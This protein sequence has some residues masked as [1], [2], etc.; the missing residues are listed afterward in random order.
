MKCLFVVVL[1]IAALFP[2]ASAQS[3]TVVVE[4][5]VGGGLSV[6]LP[7]SAFGASLQAGADNLIGGLGLRGVLNFGF[8]GSVSLSADILNYFPETRQLAPYI[9]AGGKVG[10]SAAFY[11]VHVLGGLEY[12]IDEDVAVFAELQPAYVITPDVSNDLPENVANYVG[13]TLRLGANYHFD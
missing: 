6:G 5:F 12:F 13:V 11:D 2:L 10:L 3:E 1:V 9:G 4:P 7:G 8:T